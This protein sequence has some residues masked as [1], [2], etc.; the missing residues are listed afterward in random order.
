MGR[1]GRRDGAGRPSILDPLQRLAVGADCLAAYASV[2]EGKADAELARIIREQSDYAGVI[3]NLA[4][5]RS[6]SDRSAFC[7]SEAF[8]T[9][10]RDVEEE[11][12]AMNGTSEAEGKA[13][14]LLSI[15]VERP[16]GVWAQIFADVS[17]AW[18]Q[19]IGRPVSIGT[20]RKCREE[21]EA[22]CQ[23]RAGDEL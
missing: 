8:D 5:F 14:R 21:Y 17:A 4:Q 2:A 11:R 7:R 20:V 23:R 6:K 16:R 10:R 22:F 3:S 13:S 9:H 1:G 18:S 19:R 12:H 15:K